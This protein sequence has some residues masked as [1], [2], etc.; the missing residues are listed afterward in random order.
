[1]A[2]ANASTLWERQHLSW[3]D[4]LQVASHW[5]E[6]KQVDSRLLRYRASRG[7]W[8]AL[9]A[10][11]VTLI[12]SR[13]YEHLL[14][15]ITI[16]DGSPSISYFPLPHPS[17]VAFDAK[18]AKLWVASTRN[19]NQLVSFQPVDTLLPRGD[20]R[21]I[22][23]VEKPMTPRS[24]VFL[25]GCYYI[26]DLAIIQGD[27]HANSVGQNVVVRLNDAGVEAVWWPRSVE[28]N[29]R[30]ATDRNY[31]QLNSI[32]A[33]SS[34][35]TSFY[36]ASTAAPG[37]Y[38][39]GQLLFP[40]DGRGVV[41][42]GET[43]EVY[44]TGLTR[45]HSARFIA[46]ELWIDNSGYG[47][48]GRAV[49]GKFEPA[50]KMPGWTRGLCFANDIGFVG[51]S[52]VIPRFSRYAPGLDSEKS[53]CGVHAIDMKTL[54]VL[55]SLIWPFGNQIFAIEPVPRTWTGGFPSRAGRSRSLERESALFYT[56]A[57][58]GARVPIA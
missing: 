6:A 31:L 38:R 39:P 37:R 3:R 45:P 1:M 46:E 29:G 57:P 21:A 51:T 22:S 49:H 9:D 40:V 55:G 19:P 48:F 42:S 36:S 44:T 17:G 15:A 56:F 10:A 23:P 28:R 54:S 25:P 43:R 8:D 27:L 4:P 14:L 2:R 32:A 13:E 30:P 11:N 5:H 12:V 58:A 50:L 26:H 18:H 20:V 35:G 53:V 41:F 47:E 24:T 34:V 16:R 33:G 7:W 52:R